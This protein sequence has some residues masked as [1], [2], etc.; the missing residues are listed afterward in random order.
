[1]KQL[2][3]ILAFSIVLGCNSQKKEAM[4]AKNMETTQVKKEDVGTIV[5]VMEKTKPEFSREEVIKLSKAIDPMVDTFEGYLGR[6]MTFATNEPDK[7]VDIVYY[8]DVAA[9][10]K[11][12]EIEMKSETCLTFFNT[13]IPNTEVSKMLITT[14]QF[15]TAPKP[16]DPKIVELVL[17]KTKPE[18]TKNTVVEA[19]KTI[20]PV[21]ENYSGFITRKLAVTEDGQWMDVVYWT[22]LESAKKASEDILKNPTAGQFF[23]MIDESSMDFSHLEIVIDT[24]RD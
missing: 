22:D 17:F 10:E 13:M 2:A 4:Q 11:A 8:T 14:P 5:L 18:F 20:N 15:I 23:G 1:M 19:A 24:E 21:L 3:T 12:T 6:K 16:G 7:L 9:F